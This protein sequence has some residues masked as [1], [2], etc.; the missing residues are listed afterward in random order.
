MLDAAVR[1]GVRLLETQPQPLTPN[2]S[3]NP[4]PN[5]NPDPSPDPSPDPDPNPNPEP[6]QVRLLETLAHVAD[7]RQA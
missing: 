6:D 1:P 4:D 2:H 7:A 5:P 3:P